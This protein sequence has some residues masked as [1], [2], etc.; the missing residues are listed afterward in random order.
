VGGETTAGECIGSKSEVAG[1]LTLALQ[2]CEGICFSNVA[3]LMKVERWIDTHV[4]KVVLH[5]PI[6]GGYTV[7]IDVSPA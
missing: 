4:V 2:R 7:T 1:V 5:Q 3:S 6:V